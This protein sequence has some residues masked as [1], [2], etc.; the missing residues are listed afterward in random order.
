[1]T[2]HWI[3]PILKLALQRQDY[4][5]NQMLAHNMHI[6]TALGDKTNDYG[7]ITPEIIQ[8]VEA[9]TAKILA[10][11]NSCWLPLF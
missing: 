1:M 11:K 3:Q 10:N 5:L 9:M 2:R 4:V 7:P 8:Q 6:N